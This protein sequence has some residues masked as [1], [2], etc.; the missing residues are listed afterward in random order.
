MSVSSFVILEIAFVSL[1]FE[2]IAGKNVNPSDKFLWRFSKNVLVAE[3]WQCTESLVDRSPSS[4]LLLISAENTET[5][6]FV[7][8]KLCFLCFCVLTSCSSAICGVL[9]VN[10][11]VL[12]R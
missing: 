10:S 9:S 4:S 12:K 2:P 8:L 6:T 1:L 11:Q 3:K 5:L 7:S